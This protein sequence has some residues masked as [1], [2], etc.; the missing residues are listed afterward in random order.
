MIRMTTALAGALFA[1]SAAA[2]P[3]D[4]PWH[5]I[6]GGGGTSSGGSYTLSGTIGQHD[7]GLPMTGGGFEVTGGFWAG[8]GPAGCNAADFA[9]PYGLLD[10]A[11]VLAFATAFLAGETAADIDDNGLFDLADVLAFVDAF[12]AGCP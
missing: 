6:D 2:Q 12:N 3:Y 5:T 8:V 4:I 1:A 10:L 7:A 11:D 9:P